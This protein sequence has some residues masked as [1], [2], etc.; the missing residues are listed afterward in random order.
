MID[1]TNFPDSVYKE[2]VLAPLF[3]GA[4]AHFVE[5]VRSINQAHLIMLRETQ[6]ISKTD[7]ASIATALT[8]IDENLDVSS[9]QYTGEFED[10]F[11]FVESELKKRLG[12][13]LAGA[14]HTARS[15]NDMDHTV[16]K[17]VLTKKLD[18]F[19]DYL[20]L[21]ASSLIETAKREKTTLVVAYTHGQ[22]AQPS[23]FGHYMGAAIELL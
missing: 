16:F 3:E 19:L 7:A 11:F 22:P 20:H 12:A 13:D 6:I 21:L 15:R 10:Y 1:K 4:K 23:T 18:N 9:L 17:L 14:L 5:A 8:E 2:T